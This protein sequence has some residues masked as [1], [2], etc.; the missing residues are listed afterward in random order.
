MKS[1]EVQGNGQ[2]TLLA[3]F[4]ED[5]KRLQQRVGKDRSEHTWRGLLQGRN[6]VADFLKVHE[7]AEDIC[8]ARLTPQFINDFCVWLSVYRCLRGGLV[9][10]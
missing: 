10:N 4:D 9:S 3:V 7:Q 6:Y 8:L 1:K 2:S 5:L